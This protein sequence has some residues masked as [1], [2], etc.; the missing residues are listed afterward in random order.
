MNRAGHLILH[1]LTVLVVAGVV[2]GWLTGASVAAADQLK[3]KFIGMHGDKA[4]VSVNRRIEL[5]K[6]GGTVKKGRVTLMSVSK[7]QVILR[8]DGANYLYKRNSSKGMLLPT[9]VVLAR[10]TSGMFATRGAINGKSVVFIVDTGAS[11]VSLSSE[12]ARKIKVSY[13]KN[14]PV[15]LQTASGNKTGYVTTL[16]SVRVG[17]IVQLDVGAVIIPGKFPSVILL[18]STFLQGLR[19]TQTEAFMKISQ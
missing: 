1:K 12:R 16:D 7:S 4:K 15:K 18:G 5:L 17:G 9:E 6:P 2:G 14:K 13:K 8:V 3:I 19:I 10:D 11:Y